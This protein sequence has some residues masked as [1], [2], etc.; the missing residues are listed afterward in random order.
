MI[1][2]LELDDEALARLGAE[3]SRR[4][5]ALDAV[6]NELAYLVPMADDSLRHAGSD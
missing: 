4:G 2:S 1:V 5:V 6:V 3:A